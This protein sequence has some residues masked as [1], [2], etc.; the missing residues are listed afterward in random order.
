MSFPGTDIK[1]YS[2]FIE[3]WS[4]GLPLLFTISKGHVVMTH[5]GC[6]NVTNL[7]ISK[8]CHYEVESAET[9]RHLILYPKIHSKLR[10]AV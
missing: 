7:T 4:N 9:F 2:F 1:N 3:T 10:Y 8:H 6:N 5:D